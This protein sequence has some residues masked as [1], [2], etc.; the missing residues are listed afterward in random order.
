MR[1]TVLLFALV[2]L[3]AGSAFAADRVIR[4]GSDLWTTPA[5]GGTF[6]DFGFEPIPAGFFCEGSTAFTGRISFKGVPLVT[7]EP[8]ILGTTD[9][10]IER[11]DDAAF[12]KRGVAETRIQVRALSLESIRPFKTSCG[13]YKASVSLSG[14]QPVTSMRIIRDDA[15]GGRFVAPLVLNTRITFT[16][17][18]PARRYGK[19]ELLQTVRFDASPNSW[20][21]GTGGGGRLETKAAI[22]VDTD[23]DQTPD[24]WVPATSNFAGWG[25]GQS[26]A[27][28]EEAV[29]WHTAPTHRHTAIV[30]AEATTVE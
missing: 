22:F 28:L 19:R 29:A 13:V 21:G 23:G 14:E 24:G 18:G 2:L 30:T 5:D 20:T 8:G 3:M 7:D 10:I 1:K 6:A 15:K 16:P 17:L 27:T 11:L 26:K 25:R 4:G 9:T 12:N